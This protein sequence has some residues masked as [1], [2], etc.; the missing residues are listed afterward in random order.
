M[1]DHYVLVTSAYDLAGTTISNYLKASAGFECEDSDGYGGK[2]YCSPTHKNIELYIYSGDLLKLEDVPPLF[3]Q[4]DVLIFLSKHQSR[5]S[6]PTLTCHFTGNFSADC[7][8]G[9]NSRQLAI[10]YPSLLKAYLKAVTPAIQNAP[11]YDVIM[12]ATHHGPTSID[13]PLLFIELG[14][15]EK[16]WRDENAAAVICNSLL[17]VLDKGFEHCKKIGIGLGGTHYPRKL[18]DLLLKS[19]FALAAVASKYN[20]ESIDEEIL[21]QMITR[22]KEDVTHVIVDGNGLGPQK[23]RVLTLLNTIPLETYRM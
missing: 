20:L 13:K 5:S 10:A 4:A 7:S 2:G 12:E 17:E 19:D 6:I 21:H 14:S 18:N 1:K 16:Q 22:C 3:S 15:S 23:N 9:G 8:Y 11:G